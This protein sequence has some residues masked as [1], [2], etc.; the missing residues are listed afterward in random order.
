L[1]DAKWRLVAQVYGVVVAPAFG[2]HLGGIF[3]RQA[4]HQ[5]HLRLDDDVESQQSR[6][7]F[8]PFLFP[9]EHYLGE[10]GLNLF[11]LRAAVGQQ[12]RLVRH[13]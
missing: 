5:L 7:L 3:S 12:L 10:D 11:G 2:I 13:I 4:H 8:A 9:L 6:V 1:A